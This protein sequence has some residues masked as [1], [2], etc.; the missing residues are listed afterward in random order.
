MTGPMTTDVPAQ[1]TEFAEQVVAYVKRSLGVT[2]AYD[3]ETLPVLD[4]YVR[5][6]PAEQP[7][8]R[9]LVIATAG[10]YYG[11]VVRRRMGGSWVVV[12]EPETWRLVLPGGL[13]FAP[14]GFVACAIEQTEADGYDTGMDAPPKMR[15]VFE[16]TLDG[17]SPVS[18][19]DYYS[20]C[21]RFDTLEHV[22]DVLLARARQIA[23][24]EA[25]AAAGRDKN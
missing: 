19:Q 6:V 17:M 20:L 13:S 5:Q 1:V 15:D 10:A 23:E 24:R 25:P 11:E 18:E 2:L 12:G 14:A 9:T 16:A 22:Q 21:G 7:A 8:A 4:H 3:S